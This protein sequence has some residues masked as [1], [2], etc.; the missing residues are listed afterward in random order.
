MLYD[1]GLKC[2]LVYKRALPNGGT[3]SLLNMESMAFK[4][5]SAHIS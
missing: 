4:Q 1:N 5:A 3:P 2:S